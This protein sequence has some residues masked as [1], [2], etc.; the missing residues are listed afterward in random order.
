MNNKNT[1]KKLARVHHI[2][3]F[4]KRED[5]FK[6]LEENSVASISWQKLNYIQPSF[7]FVPKDFG[8]IVEY[9]S[10]FRV[11]ELLTFNASGTKFRKDNLLVR[12]HFTRYDVEKMLEDI[13]TLSKE[14]FL[15]KYNFN[16]TKDWVL[17]EKVQYFETDYNNI[18][19][20][21]YSP[22]DT[23]FTYYPVERI[24]NIIPR[25]DS[26]KQMMK[27]FFEPNVGLLL[28][29]KLVNTQNF[30][31]I[32]VCNCM[33]DINYYGFQTYVFPLYLYAAD[34]SKT[35]NVNDEIADKIKQLNGTF[36][37]EELF[38][39]IYA[40]LHSPN[41]REK[42]KE[43]LK[44]DFPRVPYPKDRET[45]DK[46]VK[47]GKQLREL[48][49]MESPKISEASLPFPI[50]GS[51]LVERVKYE[52][53]KVFINSTQY[54]DNVPEIA[55]NFYIGGYQPAQKWLKDRKGRELS[56]EDMEHYQRII[57]VL[58]ETDKLMKEIDT[59]IKF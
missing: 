23:R 7:Y 46:F 45:F 49:L 10:G 55:W 6:F 27:N 28:M 2:D 37:P 44:I 34:G 54:F 58:L 9:E 14:D 18:R 20:V 53:S 31:T 19:K 30:S 39:Y 32:S 33:V 17:K 57:F 21:L 29:R 13:N 40:V 48:H 26:R 1:K 15:N 35:S 8:S 59:V 42:Y 36:T 11:D 47:L 25:G 4:G 38:D 41:Y 56:Y 22:F 43:F 50:E 3:L 52:D 24:S 16:E 51:D 5:K 12:N